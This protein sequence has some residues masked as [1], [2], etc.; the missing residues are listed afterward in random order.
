MKKETCNLVSQLLPGCK[1]GVVFMRPPRIEV[2]GTLDNAAVRANV[3]VEIFGWE[4]NAEEMIKLDLQ[5]QKRGST[6]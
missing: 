2:C 4:L 1:R 6:N 5:I 3:L